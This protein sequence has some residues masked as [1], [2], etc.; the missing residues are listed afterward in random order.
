MQTNAI[1]IKQDEE[2]RLAM[3]AKEL[4]AKADQVVIM[5]R[6]DLS[7]ATDLLKTIRSRVKEIEKERK[8]LVQPLNDH[9]KT[10]NGRFK[11]MTDPLG[12]ADSTIS[13]HMLSFQKQE[14]QKAAEADRQRREAEAKAEAE[15]VERIKAMIPH[16]E[17]L[18]PIELPAK[19]EIDSPYANAAHQMPA[20]RPTTYGQSGA[21]S[22][23]TKQWKFELLDIQAL[24]AARPDLV[25][26]DT[27]KIN[28]EIRGK[29]GE[30]AGLR[31]YQD[32]VLKV[33]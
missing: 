21:V 32:E 14:E 20:Y 2:T 18:E 6:S 30:I 27:V 15:R 7:S 25:M 22:T 19:T 13:R 33:R 1:A 24:A 29:G 8:A 12:E 17:M 31:V 10:I 4:C 5:D 11:A 28:Q 26:A 23:V 3:S 9:V 16:N